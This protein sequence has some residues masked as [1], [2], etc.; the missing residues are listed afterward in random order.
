MFEFVF[1]DFLI[2]S[3]V[4]PVKESEL[5]RCKSEMNYFYCLVCYA[6]KLENSF[7]MCGY[8]P[9]TSYFADNVQ[10]ASVVTLPFDVIKTHRQIEVGQEIFLKC[11]CMST[12]S[13][14]YTYATI[15]ALRL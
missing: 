1:I 9:K 13:I 3:A 2:N 4:M 6:C 11:E 12:L 10:V 7:Y 8:I 15:I 5:T 14:S